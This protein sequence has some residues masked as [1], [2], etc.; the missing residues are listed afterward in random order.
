MTIKVKH[1]SSKIRYPN[2]TRPKK[3]KFRDPYRFYVYMWLRSKDSSTAKSG[4]P[5]YV[6]KGFAN[7]AYRKGCP[8]DKSNIV[9]V[10]SR[11]L[12][13]DAFTLEI[14]LIAQYGRKDLE[15][16]ILINFTDGGEGTSGYTHTK[17]TKML[18]SKSSIGKKKTPEHIENSRKARTGMKQTPEHRENNRKSLTGRKQSQ[19]EIENNR[20]A[21]IG[22]KQTPE[23]RENNRKAHIGKKQST[24]AIEKRR[25]S[26][27]GKKRTLEQCATISA[28]LKGRKHTPEQIEKNRQGHIGLIM[29]CISCPHCGFTGGIN[30]M[31]QWHF[32]NC[33]YHPH[34]IQHNLKEV[35]LKHMNKSTQ[36][37]KIEIIKI[38]SIISFQQLVGHITNVPH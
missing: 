35:E 13:E 34:K 1:P 36:K 22:K 37:I 25:A 19:E 2:P 15:T 38:R 5:Y 20:K 12:E 3:R 7:R 29:E 32:D 18:Q 26:N 28:S 14:E 27:T 6:G 17:E 8:S 11:M 10:E 23:H 33:R 16:G 4:T 9:I 30:T 21:R 31:H 24:A